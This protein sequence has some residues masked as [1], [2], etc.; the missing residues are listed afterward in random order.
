MSH[1]LY[2]RDHE[3][4]LITAVTAILITLYPEHLDD[5]QHTSD[6]GVNLNIQ[7]RDLSVKTVNFE[8]FE[9]A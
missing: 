4:A 6:L 8:H 9:N 3:H 5:D 2:H 7:E 1:S